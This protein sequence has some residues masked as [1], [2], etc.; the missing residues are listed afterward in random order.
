MQHTY[1]DKGGVFVCAIIQYAC[2]VGVVCE[3]E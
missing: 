3:G 2:E 1:D